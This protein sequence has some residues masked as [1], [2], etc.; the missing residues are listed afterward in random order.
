M[1]LFLLNRTGKVSKF[2][3]YCDGLKMELLSANSDNEAR[4]NMLQNG[5]RILLI[6]IC[7][8]SME[9]LFL[10]GP[11]MAATGREE[12]QCHLSTSFLR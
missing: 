10:K 1:A 2:L 11:R 6:R 4:T 7:Y 3:P 8:G 12:E 9:T 5:S